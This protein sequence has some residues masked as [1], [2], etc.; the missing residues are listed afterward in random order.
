MGTGT[1]K[2]LAL[3]ALALA[4]LLPACDSGLPQPPGAQAPRAQASL[5]QLY[6]QGYRALEI[7]R[8]N[9]AATLAAEGDRRAPDPRQR[10]RFQV[11][12]AEVLMAKRDMPTALR[13]L[14]AGLAS[15][16]NTQDVRTQ[17]RALMTRAYVRCAMSAAG[18]TDASNT[19]SAQSDADYAQAQR[20]AQTHRLSGIATE[21]L[22]SR[23]VCAATRNRTIE[24]EALFQQAYRTAQAQ[25][26]KA[27]QARAAGNLGNLR[28]LGNEFDD[29]MRWLRR[30]Q[31]LGQGLGLD[32]LTAKN[33]GR[34]GWCYYR[35][36]DDDLAQQSLS[37]AERMMRRLGMDGDRVQALENL[38]RSLQRSRRHAQAQQRY[39]DAL[40][41]AS[42]LENPQKVDEATANLQALQATLALE[43]GRLRDAQTLAADALRTRSR[44]D[45]EQERLRV[46][47][48]VGQI[49]E[50]SGESANA[51]ARY[52]EILASPA[53]QPELR[54]E[55]QAAL[56]RL[57]AQAGRPREAEAAYRKAFAQME[58][59]LS[60]LI[61]AEHRLPFFSHL[62]RFH[63]DH[64]A[65]LMSQGRADEALRVADASRARMLYE[66][67]RGGRDAGNARA[68]DY[69]RLAEQLD[70][71]L[72][73]Y[74]TAQDATW[75]W[76][77]DRD[78]IVHAR[79]PGEDQ[80]A[81][82]VQSHQ[83]MILDS[84]DPLDG[85]SRDAAALYRHLLQPAAVKLDNATRVIVVADGILNELNFETLIVPGPKPHYLIEDL[86][87]SRAPALHLLAAQSGTAAVAER[88]LL[89]LG[90]PITEDAS[91]PRLPYSG[92]EVEAVTG[93]FDPQHRIVRA[94][95]AATPSAY[96][97][98]TPERFAYIHFAAHAQTSRL[99][100]LDSAV[101]LSPD[102]SDDYKLYARDVIALPLTA[103]LVTISTCR[104]AGA[105]VFSG[106]GLVGLSWAFLN[107]G[108]KRVIGGLWPVEDASTAELMTRF[109]R[110][111]A[112]GEDPAAALR[113]AKLALLRSDTAY[114]KPYYWAP[115]VLYTSRVGVGGR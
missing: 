91:F 92:K 2:R 100:P 93:Q 85:S 102:A 59:S 82:L 109:Y 98:A 65:F 58:T 97:Q 13:I 56:A 95:S 26:D 88:D 50:R 103:E 62:D 67:L 66:R 77:I 78:G 16:G 75:L 57:H 80:L 22:L 76:A 20:L 10:W 19:D 38:G 68:V 112:L 96:L 23:G 72:L 44:T 108:A 36:G 25:P 33:L 70:A 39:H 111:I 60:A 51:M 74:S 24:A 5:E 89:M 115:F 99:V 9:D 81:P 101:V 43:T 34:I 94:Q 83:R 21:L 63:D 84:Q 31:A 61:E 42:T 79:L 47:L 110:S 6:T 107:A 69:R 17:A 4:A 8:L 29:A 30:S 52:A 90:D 106:E 105:R 53:P 86:T 40:Q 55:A 28:I 14:D 32:N 37:N 1:H 48:L 114:R 45:S 49:E 46:L 41:L 27:L 15:A 18:S 64:L 73:F 12:Q 87:L 104:G 7:G 11:L 113:E 35:I 71:L 3:A 54:W